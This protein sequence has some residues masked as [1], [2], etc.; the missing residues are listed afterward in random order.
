MKKFL[1]SI[2]NSISSGKFEKFIRANKYSFRIKK[3]STHTNH[4]ST[5]Y[6]KSKYADNLTTLF[7]KHGSDKGSWLENGTH[8][9]SRIYSLIFGLSRE[10][11]SRIF[12]CGI[13]T[14]NKE[15]KSNMGDNGKPGAS[16]R[17]W[18]DF[19]PNAVIFGADIDQDILFQEER[20][21]TFYVDQLSPACINSMWTKINEKNFEIIIDDGLHTFEAGK[22]FFEN[23]ISKLHPHGLYI[24]EDVNPVDLFRYAK[25]FS[26]SEYL[27]DFINLNSLQ[28]GLRPDNNLIVIRLS[29]N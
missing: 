2:D 8:S 3:L 14:T 1:R 22:T 21:R 26:S 19:F 25:Y 17:A 20:I 28:N 10:S 18:R 24:I 9:Y 23:S 27:V 5:I 16:L 29:R 13:G 12:E 7:E 6:S 4:K 11:V 15:I